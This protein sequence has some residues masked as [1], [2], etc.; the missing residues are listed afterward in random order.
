MRH[1]RLKKCGGGTLTHQKY[2]GH[3]GESGKL[4][5]TSD[6]RLETTRWEDAMK[7]IRCWLQVS[8]MLNGLRT[9]VM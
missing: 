3:K 9:E 5:A 1:F 8:S 6:P 4:H 7:D 2:R